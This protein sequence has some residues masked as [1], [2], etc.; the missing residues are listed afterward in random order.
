MKK[1]IKWKIIEDFTYEVEFFNVD[2]FANLLISSNCWDKILYP[3]WLKNKVIS[4]CEETIERL[5]D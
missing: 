5:K 4:R 1:D 3:K 2:E